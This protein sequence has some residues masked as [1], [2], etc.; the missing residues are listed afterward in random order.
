MEDKV[1]IGKKGG[2]KKIASKLKKIRQLTEKDINEMKKFIDR[3]AE[4]GMNA[5]L[6][7]SLV[8]VEDVAEWNSKQ[9]LTLIEL[10]EED[11]RRLRV[12]GII[13]SYNKGFITCVEVIEQMKKLK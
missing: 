8:T 9:K 3:I 2:A 1:K 5:I 13:D 11:S 12:E 6:G 4:N 10:S 7:P